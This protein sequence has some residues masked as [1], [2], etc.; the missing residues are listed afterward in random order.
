[1]KK[2]LLSVTV[3]V[4]VALSANVCAAATRYDD[5]P[6]YVYIG[7]YGSGGYSTYLYLP[8]VDVQIYNPPHY[9]IAGNFVT[10]GGKKIISESREVVAVRFNLN[11][12][13]TYTKNDYG[14]WEKENISD[15]YGSFYRKRADALFRAAYG[16]DFYGY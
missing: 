11:A 8:S 5:D 3:A 1:M 13:E 4:V 2:F 7:T 16:M 10:I 9:Q 15:G 6:Y 12:K 14:H